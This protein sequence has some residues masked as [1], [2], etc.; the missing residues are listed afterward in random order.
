MSITFDAGWIPRWANT[1]VA[2][3]CVETGGAFRAAV[4]GA[5]VVASDRGHILGVAEA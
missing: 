2:F 4:S 3:E 1:L 5:V